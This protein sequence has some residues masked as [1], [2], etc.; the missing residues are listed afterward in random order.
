MTT[1]DSDN[2]SVVWAGVPASILE[3]SAAVVS[4]GGVDYLDKLIR[5]LPDLLTRNNDILTEAERMLREEKE[6]DD[7]MRGQYKERWTRTGS[8]KLTETF[9]ANAVKYKTIIGNATQVRFIE[10]RA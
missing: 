10:L 4:T 8:D 2:H 9:T 6:A 7:K 3:K 1:R 5:E